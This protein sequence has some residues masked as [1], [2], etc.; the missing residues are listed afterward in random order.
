MASEPT[1]TRPRIVVMKTARRRA[2]AAFRSLGTRATALVLTASLASSAAA[3]AA[4][5]ADTRHVV[6]DAPRYVAIGSSYAS[7]PG[8]GTYDASSGECARS[9]SNYARL[10]AV[11]RGYE[12]VDVSGSG[13]TIRDVLVG[14]E[15]LPPQIDAVDRRTRL[16]TVTIG[17]NDVGYMADL[18]G[19]SCRDEAVTKGTSAAAC[20]VLPDDEVARRFA[21]LPADCS[22]SRRRFARAHRRRRSSL[23][24]ISRRSLER[25]RARSASRSCRPMRTPCVRPTIA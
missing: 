8:V 14:S 24:S 9:T 1:A 5:T 22:P 12:L 7:G 19:R 16:V 6:R 21:A 15:S 25:E 2:A 17:G 11:A 13:A 18:L 23:S 3:G 20:E 4:S 10:F